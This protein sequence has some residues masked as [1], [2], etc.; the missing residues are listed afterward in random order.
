MKRKR[1]LSMALCV[2]L[3]VSLLPVGALAA[4]DNCAHHPEDHDCGANC[5]YICET[6]VEEIQAMVNDLPEMTAIT[7]KM[8]SGMLMVKLFS[9]AC[10]APWSRA[11]PMKV[12]M[13]RRAM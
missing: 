10:S 1:I 2:L 7:A 8:M 11:V 9:E 13:Q 3:L 12:T 6:C 5:T 4:D